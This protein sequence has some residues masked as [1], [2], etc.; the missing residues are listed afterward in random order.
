MT[1]RV[2]AAL[3]L[4]P[5]M[6]H[7]QAN[8]PAQPQA[9]KAP[10]LQSS[11]VTPAGLM[12]SSASASAAGVPATKPGAVRISTGVVGPKLISTVPVREDTISIVGLA[13]HDREV[14]LSMIVDET[15][16]PSD[17][18]IV[19]SVGGDVE[20]NILDAVSQFRYQPATVSGEV[21]S[22]PVNLHL[23]IHEAAE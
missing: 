20:R 10:V 2:A 15:G 21:I 1:I 19:G 23:V 18:K 12:L 16:K 8:T 7:A 17:L 3:L 22:I 13:K 6:V 5:L 4:S 9:A 11:L 14:L